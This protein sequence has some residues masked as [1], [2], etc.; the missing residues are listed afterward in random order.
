MFIG[1][2]LHP[3]NIDAVNWFVN[4]IFPVILE[5]I[6]EVKFYI[7]GSEPTNEV[8]QLASDNVIVTGFVED[9]SPYFEQSKVFVSP[10]RYGAGLKGKI[11]QSMSFGLPIVTTTIGAEGFI[12]EETPF[13]ISDEPEEFAK[14]VVKLYNNKSVWEKLS[15]AGINT[16]KKHYS[17]ESVAVTLN[18]I[19]K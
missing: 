12:V 1:S 19:F 11:G 18:N 3:P 2:F 15:N 16:I 10:L 7:I 6:P 17:P 9:V 4:E 8:K 5:K 13:I 14:N